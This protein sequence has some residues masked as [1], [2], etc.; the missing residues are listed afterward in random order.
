MAGLFPEVGIQ[1]PEE[2]DGWVVPGPSQ[3][4][5]ELVQALQPGRQ[6]RGNMISVN[7]GLG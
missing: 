5:G 7:S 4:Q 1:R 3:V 2:F 6:A